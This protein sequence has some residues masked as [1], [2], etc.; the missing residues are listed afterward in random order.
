MK[1]KVLIEGETP[2]TDSAIQLLNSYINSNE[3]DEIVYDN[4]REHEVAFLS[5]PE[6]LELITNSLNSTNTK[7]VILLNG[8]RNYDSLMEENPNIKIIRSA[9]HFF[10]VVYK[11]YCKR[12]G[13]IQN[14]KVPLFETDILYLNGKPHPYRC[15]L[16]DY[17][18]KST[19]HQNTKYTWCWTQA[20]MGWYPPAY[21]FV[22][23]NEQNVHLEEG[24]TRETILD[25]NKLDI[26]MKPFSQ[27]ISESQIDYFFLTEKTAKAL[28]LKQPFLV[29]GVVGFH[30][31]LEEMGF[32]LY[33]ELFDYSFD[34]ITDLNLRCESIIK[35]FEKIKSIN[36]YDMY[37]ILEPKLI[38]NMNKSIEIMNSYEHNK[39]IIDY[40]K[41]RM[42]FFSEVLDGNVIHSSYMK[43]LL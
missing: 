31:K 37:K 8:E 16:M 30:K 24:I 25:Q 15:H 36:V 11:D 21:T 18:Q 12:L 34:S 40:I 1:V 39:E 14:Y 42:E 7:F 9:N 10:R 6:N 43:N 41:P 33:T 26:T 22:N 28:F 35:E 20:D 29:L 27:L 5:R 4:S 13:D 23:W 38:Y 19:L 32:Q 3:Y 17:F 2:V